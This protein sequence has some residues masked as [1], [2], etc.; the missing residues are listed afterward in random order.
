M[1]TPTT[2]GTDLTM[3]VRDLSAS[4]DAILSGTAPTVAPSH[5]VV[6]SW[7][8]AKTSGVHPTTDRH[9]PVMLERSELYE[10]RAHHPVRDA[11]DRI[12]A[13]FSASDADTAMAMGIFDADGVLLWRGG[14]PALM[15]VADRLHLVEG[16]RWDE[17]STATTAVGLVI[18]HGRPTR[19]LGAEHYNRALHGLYCTAAP[20]H[21]RRT[22]EMVAI[23]G[24]AG[25]AAS[26]Q[27]AALAFTSAIASLGEH[28]ISA[29]HIAT[30]ADLRNAGAA[31]LA[32]VRGPGLLVDD[33][34]WVA[35]SH[36]CSGPTRVAAPADGAHQFV[37]GL[38]A[39][40]AERLPRG[41]LVR[42]A[43]P[44]SPVIAE[45]DL[46]GEPS[47]AVSG[48]TQ[49]WQTILTRRHAQILLLLADAGGSGLTA[50]RLSHMLFG[51]GSHLVTVRAEMSRLR[52]AVG[53]LVTN[54]PYRL[55][56]DVE[57]RV[58]A[59]PDDDRGPAGR[60]RGERHRFPA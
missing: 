25:P 30:L 18:Q 4:H 55:A 27:P 7:L 24:L 5:E 14:S 31:R 45:L 15:S 58:I 23:A 10:R 1:G 42:P 29:A 44:S 9:N 52:R 11:V 39:C 17:E 37:P 16:S 33:H 41:W 49:T 51:D 38:G 56:A 12:T 36:G 21:D 47:I 54:R 60:S 20:I 28:E 2:P 50:E 26:L 40:V 19:V 57:L 32:A 46:R 43:G 59:D 35:D 8:R 22:G 6:E 3:H 53:A 13:L 48:D 34:G